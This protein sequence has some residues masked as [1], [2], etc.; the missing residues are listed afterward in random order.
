MT[1]LFAIF[2]KPDSRRSRAARC[3]RR[4]LLLLLTRASYDHYHRCHLCYDSHTM[5]HRKKVLLKLIILGDSGCV[6]PHP[7]HTLVNDMTDAPTHMRLLTHLSLLLLMSLHCMLVC[8][9]CRQDVAHEPVREPKVHEPV[10]SHDR[11]RL[12]HKG[13]HDRRQARDDAGASL[14]TS[15]ALLPLAS[16]QSLYFIHARSGTRPVKSASR[17]SVSRSTAVR[18]PACSCT[19]SQTPRYVRTTC[20]CTHTVVLT[21]SWILR[22]PHVPL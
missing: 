10:Q 5:A 17:A 3:H 16:A 21:P 15:L 8:T 14:S 2:S 19:T 20:S 6:S 1:E 9:Q 18:T 7:E 12:P 11:R 13:D 4:L 22:S